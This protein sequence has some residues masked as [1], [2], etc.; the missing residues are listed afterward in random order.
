MGFFS[1]IFQKSAI[2]TS[3]D[4]DTFLKAAANSLAGVRVNEDTALESPAFYAG[5]RAVCEAFSQLPGIVYERVGES[6]KKR[7]T[8]F[9]L[10]PLIHDS[11][12]DF[13]T[14]FEFRQLM[15]INAQTH[16]VA[17]AEKIRVNNNRKIKSLLPIAPGNIKVEYKNNYEPSYKIRKSD[18]DA[19]V[20]VPRD[21]IFKL[22]GFPGE[23][24]RTPIDYLKETLG[25]SIAAQRFGAQ[26]FGNQ[27]RPGGIIKVPGNFTPEARRK[28]SEQWEAEYSGT[29]AGRTAFLAEGMDWKETG[30]SSED[31]QFLETREYQ[32]SET[33][34]ALGVSPHKIGDLKHA[35][36]SNIEHQSLEFVIYTVLPWCVRWEQAI[37]KY[38]MSEE[39]RKKYF[40]EFLV[41]GL[42]RGDMKSR[43][44]A[45]RVFIELGIMSVDEARERENLNKREDGR[46]NVYLR[47]ANLVPADHEVTNAA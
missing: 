8:S 6:N 19:W 9:H 2:R 10:Y 23:F 31:S 5:I 45:Y 32:R 20:D 4:L 47:P 14:T 29:K 38:L 30:Y 34:G 37:Q 22:V 41:D 3:A 28:L 43:S 18:K 44:E 36:F 25:L 26:L 39:E 12:N 35:T 42:L 13:Q 1:K 40:V 21:K 17:Y 27:G 15:M 16:G 46:G 11:P 24:K 33:A 7:A